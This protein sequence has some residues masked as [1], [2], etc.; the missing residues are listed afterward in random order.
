MTTCSNEHLTLS[1]ESFTAA[2]ELRVNSHKTTTPS[3]FDYR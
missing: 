2:P 3:Q 1:T